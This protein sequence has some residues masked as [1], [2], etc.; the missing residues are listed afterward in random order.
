[1]R[2][3]FSQ[4][5]FYISLIVTHSGTMFFLYWL[6]TNIHT[7]LFTLHQKI[8]SL[9]SFPKKWV[10]DDSFCYDIHVMNIFPEHTPIRIWI[11]LFLFPAHIYGN[12]DTHL[13]GSIFSLNWKIPF[14]VLSDKVGFFTERCIYA[15]LLRQKMMY[16]YNCIVCIVWRVCMW[17]WLI[18]SEPY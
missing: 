16:K 18:H 14:T 4:N 11:A 3:I 17:K 8:Y 5:T 7:D 9:H 6:C 2:G 12:I 13:Y 1:M 15:I 10:D